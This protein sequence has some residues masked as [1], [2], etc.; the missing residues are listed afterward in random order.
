[1]AFV[2]I[3]D[4]TWRYASAPST[5]QTLLAT[6]KTPEEEARVNVA[7]GG[8]S[9][10]SAREGVS[11][12]WDQAQRAV[13]TPAGILI[14]AQWSPPFGDTSAPAIMKTTKGRVYWLPVE[15][16]RSFDEFA[17]VCCWVEAGVP[18]G[19][20]RRLSTPVPGWGA[21]LALWAAMSAL[22]ILLWIAASHFGR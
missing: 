8:L 11:N 21:T 22:F 12:T 6:G 17:A 10:S 13:M 2:W 4:Q 5:L 14:F 1:M 18:A 20:I 15:G 9:A 7:P 3:V 19:K 16:F